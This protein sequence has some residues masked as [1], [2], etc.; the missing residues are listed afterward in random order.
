MVKSK[1]S[2]KSGKNCPVNYLIYNSEN[3][4]FTGPFTVKSIKEFQTTVQSIFTKS[5]FDEAS[6][7]SFDEIALNCSMNKVVF[8]NKAGQL[9]DLNDSEQEE[10]QLNLFNSD[11]SMYYILT[12][13]RNIDYY[14]NVLAIITHDSA[15]SPSPV[16]VF[17][18]EKNY[19]KD[20]LHDFCMDVA[21]YI[22][23]VKDT[24]NYIIEQEEGAE[25][26]ENESILDSIIIH[27]TAEHSFSVNR[28]YI[29]TY[30]QK[31]LIGTFV[32]VEYKAQDIKTKKLV[33]LCW[34]NH[35]MLITDKASNQ[36]EMFFTPISGYF[37]GLYKLSEKEQKWWFNN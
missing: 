7:K 6:E 35:F 9:K 3:D 23:S 37:M 14:N 24:V 10:P 30:A 5:C 13:E 36:A 32:D 34:K 21:A 26:E 2:K 31:S 16:M 19:Y 11:S 29:N 15:Y 33:E 25:D 1:T 20:R 18:D 4:K 27:P 12:T 17:A 28:E 8:S 22:N